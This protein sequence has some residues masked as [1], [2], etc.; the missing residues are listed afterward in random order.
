MSM[1]QK[2][3]DAAGEA[4][5]SSVAVLLRQARG[6]MAAFERGEIEPMDIPVALDSTADSENLDQIENL[7]FTGDETEDERAVTRRLHGTFRLLRHMY[8]DDQASLLWVLEHAAGPLPHHPLTFRLRT[9]LELLGS[10]QL[11]PARLH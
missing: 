1:N 5:L 4:L 11:A 10:D 7:L 9:T 6:M 8:G 3:S 2:P